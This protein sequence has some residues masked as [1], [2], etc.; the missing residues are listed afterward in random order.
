MSKNHT[1]PGPVDATVGRQFKSPLPM[2]YAAML[3]GAREMCESH[4][5]ALAIHGSM[6]RDFDIIAIPWR[7]DCSPPSSVIASLTY[8]LHHL[9]DG[10]A[11]GPEQKP[12]GRIAWAIP[13]GN[14]AVLDVS[15][16]PP[17]VKPSEPSETRSAAAPCSIPTK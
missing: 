12:H 16:M 3:N 4:G 1:S 5:Y 8:A 9:I 2:I 13:M 15:I 7:E 17:N 11:E 6:S 10:K 14:G